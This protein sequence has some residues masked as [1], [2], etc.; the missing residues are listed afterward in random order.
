M[1]DVTDTH[2]RTLIRLLSSTA[3]LYI[4]MI[5]DIAAIARPSLLHSPPTHSLHLQLAGSSLSSLLLATSLLPHPSPYSSI[6][7]NVGCPASSAQHGHWGAALLTDP[8]YPT[9]LH[10]LHSSLSSSPSSPS[11]SIPLSIKCR[12]G[13]TDPPDYPTFSRFIHRMRRT[14][15]IRHFIVHC[16]PALLH[17]S[18]THNLHIPPLDHSFA[19]RIKAEHGADI[20]V[21]VNGGVDGEDKVRAWMATDVD[22]LM[23]GRWAYK[24]VWD[25]RHIDRWVREWKRVRRRMGR[26]RGE[27]GEAAVEEEE[28]DEAEGDV[29]CRYAVLERYCEYV[30]GVDGRRLGNDVGRLLRP[31]QSLWVGECGCKEWRK[32]LQA[33]VS[34]GLSAVDAI[35]RAMD[36][37]EQVRRAADVR[38]MPRTFL[39]ALPT[40]RVARADAPEEGGAR[41]QAS[42]G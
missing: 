7:L 33:G 28:W 13:L 17:L 2:F 42:A 8:T 40:L 25:M 14:A 3:H 1:V 19:H 26:G 5:P 34:D 31:L 38:D 6:N 9:T 21:E 39:T 4:P 12:I 24:A 10:H 11:P 27:E 35:R 30:A 32:Q 29:V 20:D 15:H 37:V 23:I 36:V 41:M 22:G 16:R 18:T